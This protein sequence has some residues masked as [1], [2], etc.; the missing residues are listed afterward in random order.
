MIRG[1]VSVNRNL[2]TKIPLTAFTRKHSCL[3][4]TIPI[5]CLVVTTVKVLEC[6]SSPSAADQA[7]HSIAQDGF[8]PNLYKYLFMFFTDSHRQ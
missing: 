8:C 7:T 4:Q 1:S 5:M 3:L 2:E 6:F